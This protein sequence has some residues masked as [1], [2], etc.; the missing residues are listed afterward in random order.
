MAT[1]KGTNPAGGAVNYDIPSEGEA[2]RSVDG[3]F[4]VRKGDKLFGGSV[5]DIGSK[6]L[7]AEGKIASNIHVSQ[8]A[9]RGIDILKSQGIDYNALKERGAS[10]LADIQSIYSNIA[11]LTDFSLLK[12]TATDTEEV[13][14]RTPAP[15]NPYAALDTS[16]TRGAL[17]TPSS[18]Q[19]NLARAGATP[20]QIQ[21]LSGAART[22]VPYSEAT[23][24][25]AGVKRPEMKQ[26]TPQDAEQARLAEIARINGEANTTQGKDFSVIKSTLGNTVDES[27]SSKI[28]KSLVNSFTAGTATPKAPSMA[29]QFATQRANLGVGD[30]E[31]QLSNINAEIAKLDNEFA[32]LS[33]EETNRKVSVL[34]I[35]RRKTDQQIKYESARRDLDTKKN[36]I[37]NELNQKYSVIENI[38]KY[39]G[40]DYDNAQ[41]DY[42][43]KF[44]QAIALTN[45]IKGVED[46]AKSDAERK[47]DNARANLQV[48]MT[49]LKG[50]DYPA[51]DS[52]TQ[53]DIKN[54]EL[55]AGFPAGFTQFISEAVDEPVVSIG[56]EFTDANG[57]RQVPVYTKNTNTGVVSAE[58]IGLGTGKGEDLGILDVQRYKDLYP[59]AGIE[60][61]DT[62]TT[63]EAKIAAS[64]SPEAKTRN[65]IVSAR[66][67]G[68]SYE[69]V[70]KEIDKDTTI[71]DKES[72]KD[73]A[74]EVYGIDTATETP[75]YGK[76]S[77]SSVSIDDRIKQLQSIFS[78]QESL[79][80]GQL[81]KDGYPENEVV[82]KVGGLVDKI[83][84][85]ANNITD[86]ISNFLFNSK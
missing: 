57:N 75:I 30:K 20:N 37:V 68:N 73:I 71:K 48:M 22:G 76:G 21:V 69:T 72:A 45:L 31:T 32:T 35:N 26:I 66:D 8:R 49:Q 36:V 55:Q 27:D 24:A 19:A 80:K 1:F 2:F 84:L 60:I 40:M 74:R 70:V 17:N 51:L 67:N 52:A 54:M 9:K 39:A 56:S 81:I 59:D 29:E 47:S 41:Q 18:L 85:V 5:E 3:R 79:I 25:T 23:L 4:Y 62:K 33:D 44:N 42:N 28:L 10:N 34:Q 65:L 13:I 7:E 63:A 46:S 82:N 77:F 64:N 86:S 15:N 11:P 43:T 16:S 83:G 38:M 58:L 61:G 6:A 53:A 78:G 14:T 50:K 12:S